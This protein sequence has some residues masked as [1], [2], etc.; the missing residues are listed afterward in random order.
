M[1][2]VFI[3]AYNA[4]E[5]IDNAIMSLAIQTAKDFMK[6]IIIN[7]GSEKDYQETVDKFSPYIHIE[8][9][10]HEKNMGVGFARQTALD[11][12]DTKYFSFLDSDDIYSDATA[13]Q[14]MYEKMEESENYI[15]VF[16]QFYEQ[17]HN[18]SY[19]IREKGESWI[20]SKMYRSSF[21]RKNNLSFPKQKANEDNVF[22][23]SLIGSLKNGEVIVSLDKPIY[24]W[25]FV[26]TSITRSN[27]SEH[28]FYEDMKGLIDGLYY[29]KN[30]PNISPAY[31]YREIEYA[32]FH[33]YFRYYDNLI[34]KRGKNF[35]NDILQLSKK[36]YH[37]ILWNNKKLEE[38]EYI[39]TLFSV[40]ALEFQ[41]PYEN[42]DLFR[43]FVGMVR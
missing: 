33:L 3:P 8:E 5:F 21:I 4:H 19:S 40:I 27:N 7:D 42:V 17:L 32:F 37:E 16:A 11:I 31:W 25:N 35:A 38:E 23:I 22:N 12:L 20:F 10:K 13:F 14:S 2:S 28:W 18:G 1:I 15:A 29:I 6:V 26:K 36:L 39:K 43:E 30:N 9:F 34:Y 24:L 41:K